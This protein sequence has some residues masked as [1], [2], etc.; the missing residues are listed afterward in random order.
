[1]GLFCLRACALLLKMDALNTRADFF[2]QNFFLLQ[3]KELI[4]LTQE[5]SAA[6][7][8]DPRYGS[9]DRHPPSRYDQALWV[10]RVWIQFLPLQLWDSE[11]PLLPS[12]LSDPAKVCSLL[13]LKA[14]RNQLRPPRTPRGSQHQLLSPEVLNL[15]NDIPMVRGVI[16]H[17]VTFL[18]AL[19]TNC[20][21][22]GLVGARGRGACRSSIQLLW[23]RAPGR[24]PCPLLL[25][26]LVAPGLQELGGDKMSLQP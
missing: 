16:E 26:L 14:L 10:E 24:R 7:T 8:V 12:P 9:L 21:C 2:Q 4:V 6:S 20:S 1:M 11:F 22:P 25:L 3:D 23:P 17:Q 19:S 18:V 15:V 5:L 13:D